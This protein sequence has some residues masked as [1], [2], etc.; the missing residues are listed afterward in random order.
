MLVRNLVYEIASLLVWR[1]KLGEKE[2]PEPGWKR[3]P[4]TMINTL[5]VLVRLWQP[6]QIVVT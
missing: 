4:K 3:K 1:E 6:R 5:F 2:V